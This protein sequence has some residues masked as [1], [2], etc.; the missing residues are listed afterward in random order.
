MSWRLERTVGCG[1]V[2]IKRKVSKKGCDKRRN[3]TNGRYEIMVLG[4][5]LNGQVGAGYW[6]D[7]APG[8]CE[9]GCRFGA[10]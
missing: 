8:A 1:F 10:A 7:E 9:D 6:D 5:S 2:Q 3:K 4:N